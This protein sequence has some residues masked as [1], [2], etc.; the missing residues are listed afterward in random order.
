MRFATHLYSDQFDKVNLL[1]S[2]GLVAIQIYGI[3]EG[4]LWY[5][6]N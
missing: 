6:Y 4:C 3:V 5:L 1:K 2:V